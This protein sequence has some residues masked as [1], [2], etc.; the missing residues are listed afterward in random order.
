M[1][2]AILI[3]HTAVPYLK[4]SIQVLN[5][6]NFL[7]WP[8]LLLTTSPKNVTVAPCSKPR[9]LSV[10]TNSLIENRKSKMALTP[11]KGG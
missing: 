5:T 4:L 7:M 9:L 8:F 1:C 6:E 10:L 2:S 11:P 3:I